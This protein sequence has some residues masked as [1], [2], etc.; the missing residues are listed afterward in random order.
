MLGGWAYGAIYGSSRERTAALD[1]WLWHLQPSPTTPSPRPPNTHHPPEQPARDLHLAARSNTTSPAT[2]VSTT[3]SSRA[4][5]KT[6][7]SVAFQSGA[8]SSTASS[9]DPGGG[10]EQHDVGLLAG[11]EVAADVV[12]PERFRSRGGRQPQ[13]LLRPEHVALVADHLHVV[14]DEALLEHAQ[15]R[16]P[17]RRRCPSRS[18]RRRRRGAPSG[19]CRR[20]G[21][22]WRTGSA[23]RPSWSSRG[24]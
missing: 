13:Q 11:G 4:S 9:V 8:S 24:G 10:F 17:R 3:H 22:R 14:G 1:G 20:P 6:A 16:C 12:E 2:R 19:R 7:P 21:R 5:V 23:R 15:A 18:A